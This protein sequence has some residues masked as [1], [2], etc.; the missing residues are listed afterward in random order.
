MCR[1]KAN[2]TAVLD[3]AAVFFQNVSQFS[4]PAKRQLQLLQLMGGLPK[5]ATARERYFQVLSQM[6]QIYSTSCVFLNRWK[7]LLCL[8]LSLSLSH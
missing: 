8:S 5:N 6:Q 3:N 1:Q 7:L 4:D 2:L